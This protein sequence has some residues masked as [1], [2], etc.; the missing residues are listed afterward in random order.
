MLGG[1]LGRLASRAAVVVLAGTLVMSSGAAM[2]ASYRSMSCSQLWYARNAIYA[3]NG[4]CFK[5]T[6]AIR[7]FGR[8][9]YPPYGRLSRAE[10]REVDL[11]V[12]WERR[13]GCR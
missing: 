8:A 1:M 10:Q 11:I 5:T 12:R 7:A 9:C 6:R 2:A 3:D 4:Y 13:K